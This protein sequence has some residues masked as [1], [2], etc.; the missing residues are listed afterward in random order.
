[1]SV[2]HHFFLLALLIQEATSL[3]GRWFGNGKKPAPFSKK[4]RDANPDASKYGGYEDGGSSS[5]SSG[6]GEVS[7]T[8]MLLFFGICF[9]AY[10]MWSRKPAGGASSTTRAAGT[11]RG[12]G[13]N[14]L[15][16]SR[17]ATT[18]AAARTIPTRT[19]ARSP[20]V[21]TAATAAT[22]TPRDRT[23]ERE[24]RLRALDRLPKNMAD[25]ARAGNTTGSGGGGGGGGGAR[26]TTTAS[27]G[28]GARQR[29][30]GVHGFSSGSAAAQPLGGG[31]VS[32]T[33]ATADDRARLI[34]PE[35][36]KED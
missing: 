32:G 19:P 15:G 22:A 1:M 29:V 18:G 14:T 21:P 10:F 3:K 8:K 20:V 13:G 35:D 9:A 33:D 7:N 2:L 34:F 31:S 4:Y 11:F 28:G 16:S 27:S 23:K 5:S 30:G 17:T 25:A 12:S 24:A 36:G 26:T 6:D